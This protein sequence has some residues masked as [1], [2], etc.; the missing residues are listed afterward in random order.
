M[1]AA[2]VQRSGSSGRSYECDEDNVAEA[3]VIWDRSGS[4]CKKSSGRRIGRVVD[5]C[6]GHRARHHALLNLRLTCSRCCWL[7]D[8]C[9]LLLGANPR[10]TSLMADVPQL[11]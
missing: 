7:D 2:L 4:G 5:R 10:V 1:V 6:G 8:R 3:I 11:S 9:I